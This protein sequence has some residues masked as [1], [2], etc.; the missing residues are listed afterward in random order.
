MIDHISA[1][2]ESATDRYV[3]L[4]L[5]VQVA[6][7]VLALAIV[8]LLNPGFFV[9]HV[10]IYVFIFAAFG[11]SWN[12]LGGYTGQLS[13]G[14]AVFFAVGAYAP[15]ILFVFY[16][17]SPIIGIWI[18]G[19]L[20]AFIALCVG[21][22]TFRLQGH[23]FAMGTL[24]IALIFRQLFIRWE[25]IQASRGISMPLEDIGTLVS[26]TFTSREPYFYLIGAFALAV[27]V[28][29][30]VIDG[31]KL[32]LYLKAI[33][34]DEELAENA[35]LNTFYYKMYAS[36]ISGFIAGVTGGLYALYSTFVDPNSVLDLFRNIEPVIVAL[37]GGAGTVLG[38]VIGAFLFVPIHEYSR[39]LLSGPYTGLGWVVMGIVIVALAIF[40]PGGVLGGRLPLV[41]DQGENE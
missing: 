6:I 36:G 41:G 12:V 4:P 39:S 35:G 16:D 11:H 22:V 21:A 8:P 2:L 10:L 15:M 18:G 14:H 27:T 17:I 20:G 29:V 25:W 26:L 5:V 13:F 38:P 40:R 31:S 9:M 7:P 32:G 34:M 1:R 23:Y 37:I 19:L 24:A 33:N 3:D 30:Y 28:A